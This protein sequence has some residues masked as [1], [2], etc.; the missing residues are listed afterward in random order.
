MACCGGGSSAP[1]PAPKGPEA[2]R[3]VSTQPKPVAIEIDT[4]RPPPASS[5][6][7]ASPPQSPSNDAHISRQPKG[8]PSFPDPAK[9]PLLAGSGS[10][11]RPAT[12][13][14]MSPPLTPKQDG[15]RM[16]DIELMLQ[17]ISAPVKVTG[18]PTLERRAPS[19][20]S[21]TPE[22]KPKAPEPKREPQR[23]PPSPSPVEEDRKQVELP[24]IEIPNE[25]GKPLDGPGVLKL[26]EIL[27]RVWE[28]T[29]A[30]TEAA[31]NLF[32]NTDH[33][34][35]VAER[36]R[37]AT[38]QLGRTV[39]SRQ[40]SIVMAEEVKKFA[41]VFHDTCDYVIDLSGKAPL[42]QF[43]LY[44]AT[45]R[46][47]STA[48][49]L[50]YIAHRELRTVEAEA[51]EADVNSW[52]EFT[53]ILLS[54]SSLLEQQLEALKADLT[55][56]TT[57]S[58]AIMTYTA[59]PYPRAA[60]S[61]PV[62]DALMHLRWD[63][64][65]E[66]MFAVSSTR[67]PGEPA[68]WKELWVGVGKALTKANP[69]ALL[70]SIEPP[71]PLPDNDIPV[72][73]SSSSVSALQARADKLAARGELDRALVDRLAV[74]ALSGM[75]KKEY[76]K[77]NGII[78]EIV[79]R[80][81]SAGAE[82]GE[83]Q[84]G[85]L[86]AW[87]LSHEMGIDLPLDIPPSSLQ[88]DAHLA[89]A[90]DRFHAQDYAESL[91]AAE[92]AQNSQV[93][94]RNRPILAELLAF[95][96]VTSGNPGV[97]ASFFEKMGTPESILKAAISQAREGDF[98]KAR[99]LAV[100]ACTN[101]TATTSGLVLHLRGVLSAALEQPSTFAGSGSELYE[102]AKPVFPALVNAAERSWKEDGPEEGNKKF[103]ALLTDRP[104]DA[105]IL[106]RYARC[107]VATKVWRA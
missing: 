77:W 54:D 57:Q 82:E 102:N 64:V 4:F 63:R 106:F 92:A 72:P 60:V 107:M 69:Y 1:D 52:N 32:A 8:L 25:P 35:V 44:R 80:R 39:S 43:S 83:A 104:D 2:T 59:S 45:D 101:P 27:S 100:F 42:I 79:A 13:T 86:E 9:S 93:S 67:I 68:K 97:G 34:A 30:L 49:A 74:W 29:G 84:V 94:E 16:D 31:E 71:E 48:T 91:R 90:L 70:P 50:K 18:P 55:A 76:D 99:E 19:P 24:P 73:Y 11:S 81:M 65:V 61:P 85:D 3:L 20:P 62:V 23:A 78:G 26:R 75:L 56:I 7:P 51:K 46:I 58:L 87:W 105:Y 15:H 36:L 28:R 66:K 40:P 95:G 6:G 103:L 47:L 5:R 38:N 33:A 21:K 98:V 10:L 89:R 53:D 37:S 14:P 22:P 96:Y 12:Q 17:G 41:R 88:G